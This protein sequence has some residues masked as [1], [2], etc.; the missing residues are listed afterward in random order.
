[1]PTRAITKQGGLG[2]APRAVDNV[3]MASRLVDR[4]ALL[5]AQAAACRAQVIALNA[6]LSLHEN[7][8]HDLRGLRQQLTESSARLDHAI[9]G[10]TDVTSLQ[11]HLASLRP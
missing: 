8:R 7:E 9:E 11:Q 5:R 2:A 4:V 1:M 6:R 10:I 3:A